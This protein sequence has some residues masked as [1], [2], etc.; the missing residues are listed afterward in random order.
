MRDFYWSIAKLKMKR[1]KN[2]NTTGETPFAG[3]QPH[4]LSTVVAR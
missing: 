3:H 2:K 4:P 1:K